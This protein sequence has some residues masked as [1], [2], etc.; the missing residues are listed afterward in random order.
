[1][2]KLAALTR[3][4]ALG[5]L[6]AAVGGLLTACGGSSTNATNSSTTATTTT[7]SSAACA[8]TATE[9]AGPYPDILGMLSNPAFNWTD[10]LR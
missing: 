5:T 10:A 2:Q 8:V 3:G 9:T 6:G 7:G 1:M 4:E